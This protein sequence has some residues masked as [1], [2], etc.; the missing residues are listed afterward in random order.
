V[1]G[2]QLAY[3]GVWVG[4]RLKD[5]GFRLGETC[6]IKVLKQL[7]KRQIDADTFGQPYLN[8]MILRLDCNVVS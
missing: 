6:K 5:L 8:V 4:T 2:P 7:T 1:K 3:L